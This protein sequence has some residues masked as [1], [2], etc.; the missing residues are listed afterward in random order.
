[1]NI[2]PCI[3]ISCTFVNVLAVNVEKYK[4]MVFYTDYYI[5]QAVYAEQLAVL[6]VVPERVDIRRLREGYELND[7]LKNKIKDTVLKMIDDLLYGYE[8]RDMTLKTIKQIIISTPSGNEPAM[9]FENYCFLM[10]LFSC[11][12]FLKSY[13]IEKAMIENDRCI[14]ISN[15]EKQFIYDS[16]RAIVKK[17]T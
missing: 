17:V 5:Q 10:G 9:T 1:M 4:K 11:S 3:L 14:L 8:R 6:L 7:V 16:I 2:F 15:R 12:G 13:Y